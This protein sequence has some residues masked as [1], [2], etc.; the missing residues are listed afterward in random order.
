M[1]AALLVAIV[2]GLLFSVNPILGAIAGILFPPIGAEYGWSR[3]ALSVGVSACTLAIAMATP[4]M[5]NIIERTSP[6]LVVLTSV[7][8]FSCLLAAFSLMPGN[9]LL[10]IGFLLILGFVGAGVTPFAYL[11][12]LPRWFDRRLGMSLGIGMTGVGFGQTLL[13]IVTDTMNS[14]VGWR[15]TLVY[16]GVLNVL[17]VL[18]LG[19]LFYRN[20]PARKITTDVT[21][22]QQREGLSLR[23]ARST[24]KFWRM[25]IAFFLVSTIG[26]GCIVHVA[27]MIVDRGYSSG[28]GAKVLSAIG[29]A[30]LLSRL[31]AGILLDKINA[32]LVGIVTFLAAAI[33]ALILIFAPNLTF[34]GIGA[35]MVGSGLGTEGDLMAFMLRRCFGPRHYPT[36]YGIFGG[37]YGAGS[38]AG[39]LVLG[40]SYD[41]LGG[42]ETG[43]Y[44][45]S[46]AALIS[47]LL[48]VGINVPKAHLPE[49]SIADR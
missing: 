38:L 46:V 20:P 32:T 25:A 21:S 27:P 35:F 44:L 29:V 31:F 45:F 36:I 2:S 17:L 3:T 41:Y 13:P 12:I 1:R 37:I 43:L 49:A 10:F 48:L 9:Y 4:V 42:Y 16:L 6:R 14:A 22:D 11:S 15:T 8:M 5:G 28:D 39:P 30:V 26:A 33:G 19:F 40:V 47:A 34:L 23:D 7:T 18:P 24:L